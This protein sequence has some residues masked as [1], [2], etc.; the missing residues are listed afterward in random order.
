MTFGKIFSFW[1]PNLYDGDQIPILEDPGD[2]W[3]SIYKALSEVPH[4]ES[5]QTLKT[6]AIL[7][8]LLCLDHW[9]R[10]WEV[11]TDY[12]NGILCVDVFLP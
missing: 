11:G 6:L 7:Y 1:F 9:D 8:L 10:I 12:P 4:F 3:D 5:T 2:D